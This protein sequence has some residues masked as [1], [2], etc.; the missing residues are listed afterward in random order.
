ML[1][2]V[3]DNLED[4][5]ADM[6]ADV[7]QVA[8]DLSYLVIETGCCLAPVARADLATLLV[9]LAAAPQCLPIM[10]CTSLASLAARLL[11]PKLRIDRYSGTR[12]FPLGFS[13]PWRPL[14]RCCVTL[15]GHFGGT[16]LICSKGD[17]ARHK[18]A[19]LLLV[20]LG[21]CH[22]ESNSFEEI[23]KVAEGI[24]TS[25]N[26]GGGELAQLGFLANFLPVEVTP[27]SVD[28]AMLR[29]WHRAWL[30]TSP[31]DKYFSPTYFDLLRRVAKAH[32]SAA[33][34]RA[35]S[36]T[37]SSSSESGQDDATEGLRDA[38][39][40]ILP[41]I[42]DRLEACCGTL[43]SVDA[44][45]ARAVS[46]I[47]S[48]VRSASIPASATFYCLYCGSSR[49]VPKGAKLLGHLLDLFDCFD[50]SEHSSTSDKANPAA[51]SI[52]SIMSRFTPLFHPSS[53]RSHFHELASFLKA[54]SGS[55]L[56]SLTAFAEQGSRDRLRDL[57]RKISSTALCW[58][59][60]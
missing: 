11:M 28:P 46:V 39:S 36:S 29:A 52:L 53:S 7:S 27:S 25:E 22:F 10:L 54:V 55:V 15:R 19:V 35:Y 43:H 38:W 56:P 60:D 16:R 34:D 49:G 48:P 41:T 2:K 51:L 13:L 50:E 37:T 5:T 26:A 17:I 31:L 44:E 9:E 18:A 4:A 12:F 58:R 21:R 42:A 23:L 3:R 8:R 32:A 45:A 57:V 24:R 40:E 1:R 59:C 6:V 14:W 30:E 20:R 47:N 33:R